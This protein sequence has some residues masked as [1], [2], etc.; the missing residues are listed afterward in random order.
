VAPISSLDSH[1]K[2]SNRELVLLME[3]MRENTAVNNDAS[4]LIEFQQRNCLGSFHLLIIDLLLM[5]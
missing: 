3:E 4:S 2:R 5:G 1:H